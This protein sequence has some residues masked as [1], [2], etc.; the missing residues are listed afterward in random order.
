MRTDH[1]LHHKRGRRAEPSFWV[2]EATDDAL[3]L[4]EKALQG[5]GP[6]LRSDE[7]AGE[8]RAKRGRISEA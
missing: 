3:S 1:P 6:A 7:H 8:T 4:L 5:D 2:D